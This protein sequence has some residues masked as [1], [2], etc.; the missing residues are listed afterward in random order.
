VRLGSGLTA[1]NDA[2][3]DNISVETNPV[4]EPSAVAL[5]LLGAAGL[6]GRPSRRR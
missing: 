2:N 3:F 1:V 4:P 6:V 5:C